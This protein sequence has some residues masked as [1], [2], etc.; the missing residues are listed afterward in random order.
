MLLDIHTSISKTAVLT[1]CALLVLKV[2]VS[3]IYIFFFHPL[4]KYPGPPLARIS[5][6]WSRI[7]NFQGRKSERI[8]EAHVRYGSVVRV[9]PN[10]LSFST[11]TAVQAIYTSND[12]AKEE[13]FYASIQLSRDII[14]HS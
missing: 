6:L 9:G 10:E 12:F 2:A 14:L 13:S 11:P 1:L 5:R 7:G 4:S 3:I 8:H